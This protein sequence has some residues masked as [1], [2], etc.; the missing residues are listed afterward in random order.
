MY[1]SAYQEY[2]PDEEDVF[3]FMNVFDS[4]NDGKIELKD[5]EQLAVKYLCGEDA[6]GSMTLGKIEE[7]PEQKGI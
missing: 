7:K 3:S 2:K 5:I 6:L 1:L 4:N